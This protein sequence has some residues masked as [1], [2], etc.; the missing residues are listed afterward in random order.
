MTYIVIK[1]TFKI[2]IL[3]PYSP[4]DLPTAVRF[5][6]ILSVLCTMVEVM[7]VP[8]DG[9]TEQQASN[10]ASFAEELGNDEIRI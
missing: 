3:C 5:R 8:S 2:Y 6:T 10:R 9:E 7:R 4:V 1:R